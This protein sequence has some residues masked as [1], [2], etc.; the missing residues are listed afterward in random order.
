[1]VQKYDS[2]WRSKVKSQQ[3]T[4]KRYR[5]KLDTQAVENAESKWRPDDYCTEGVPCPATLEAEDFA[6]LEN[7]SIM[8]SCDIHN[9]NHTLSQCYE[10]ITETHRTGLNAESESELSFHTDT[11]QFVEQGTSD[12]NLTFDDD[13]SF[14]D[15]VE[16]NIE[17]G[18]KLQNSTN[19]GDSP[20]YRNAPI[21]VA[22][23]LLLIITFANRHKITGKVLSD[24]LCTAPLTSKLNVFRFKIFF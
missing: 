19:T 20:L 13:L 15:N 3:S 8:N 9:S 6:D 18:T 22:E 21:S 2:R 10:Y 5:R 23:S 24:L 11:F 17:E 7:P 4:C 1:M 16:L 12:D 14:E